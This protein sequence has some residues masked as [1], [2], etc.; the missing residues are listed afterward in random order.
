MLHRLYIG[1]NLITILR[2]EQFLHFKRFAA[3]RAMTTP[4]SANDGFT[5]NEKD[6]AEVAMLQARLK[7]TS[8]NS[9]RSVDSV[10]RS[11]PQPLSS[12]DIAEGAHKYVLIKAELDGEEQYVVTSKK[13]AEYHRNAAEPMINILESAG[14]TNIDVTGGGRL[15]LDSNAKEIHIYGFSYGFGLADHAISQKTVVN[16]PRYGSFKVTY[17][18][19]GY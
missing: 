14:Y 2:S 1:V 6:Q 16:D 7:N 18:N 4:T 11:R 3:V 9:K 19:E 5:T 13:G 12:V 10:K 17:S 15:S 8:T